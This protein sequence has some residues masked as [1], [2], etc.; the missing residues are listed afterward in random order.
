M[1][2]FHQPC[3]ALYNGITSEVSLEPVV[4]QQLSS[5]LL[6]T[7]ALIVFFFDEA[8]D[9][10]GIGFFEWLGDVVFLIKIL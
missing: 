9:D 6:L 8:A 1:M 7:L 2:S 5:T 10:N 3:H 4:V